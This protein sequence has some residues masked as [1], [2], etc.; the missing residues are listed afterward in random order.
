MFS[1]RVSVRKI[2]C[3]WKG[4]LARI[5][6][7]LPIQGKAGAAAPLNFLIETERCDSASFSRA[8][9]SCEGI[10][11]FPSEGNNLFF[12]KIY[13]FR[14]EQIKAPPV[15]EPSGLHTEHMPVPQA[16]SLSGLKL[17]FE[18]RNPASNLW[19]A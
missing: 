15:L 13:S 17:I 11:I 3:K 6:G 9:E 10:L 16:M 4:R 1:S 12:T 2:L 14:K 8:L 19:P 7:L 5:A 18:L